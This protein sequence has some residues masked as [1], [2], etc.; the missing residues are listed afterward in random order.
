MEIIV[1]DFDENSYLEHYDICENYN[2][3]GNFSLI[4]MCK[5]KLIV[6]GF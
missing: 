3:T 1:S 4:L 5:T 6:F 2:K